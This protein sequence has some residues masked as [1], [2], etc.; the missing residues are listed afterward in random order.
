M[1]DYLSGGISFSGIGNGTDFQSMIEQLKKIEEIPKK[2]LESSHAGWTKKYKAFEGLIDTVK[3]AEKTLSKFNSISSILK[4]TASLSNSSVASVVASADVPD[5][6]YSIDVKQ[7]A[8]NS[9]LSNNTVFDSKTKNINPGSAT[10][11][12][13][14]EYKGQKYEVEVPPNADLEYLTTL[15][16]KDSSNPGVKASLVKTGDGYMFSLEGNETGA[17]ATLNI[18]SATT[19]PSFSPA[20]AT[21]GPLANGPDTIINTTGTVQQ[22]SVNYN[23]KDITFDIPPGSTA[24]D[25]EQAINS[26]SETTGFKASFVKDGTDVSLQL[27]GSVSGEVVT[28]TNS[29]TDLGAF[30]SSGE[31]GWNK[32]DAQDA[33]FSVNDWD[34]EFTSSSN[35][36]TEVIEGLEINLTDTGKTQ[37]TVNTSTK[38]SKEEIEKAV[39]SINSVLGKIQE[40]TSV[41]T[42]KT[43]EEEEL[44][45][46]LPSYLAS[47]VDVNAGPFAGSSGLQMFSSRFKSILSS[48]GVGF[49]PPQTAGGPGDIFSSLASIGI[50]IDAEE[51]SETFGKLKI[52]DRETIGANSPFTT[53]DEALEKDPQSVADILAGSSGVSDSVAFSYET[54]LPGTTK[55]GTYDVQY[56]VNPDGTMGDVFIGGVKAT[57]ADSAKN[58]YTVSSGPA[59]GL[60]ITIKDMTPGKSVESTVRVQQGKIGELQE[61]LKAETQLDPLKEN[62][63]P[64]IIMQDSYKEV[65]RNIETKLERET[66]RITRWE[67]MMRL[68]FSRLDGVLAKYDQMMGANAASLGQLG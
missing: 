52:L 44:S 65:M 17:E 15:I 67:R 19:L 45:N 34:Q 37:I 9:V 57:L 62:T 54:H 58:I 41:S 6:T 5:G 20:A 47:P 56:T 29:P 13:A 38:E 53:L 21:S 61:S 23:G 64:L 12:F 59:T 32:R 11:V 49:S 33:I 50:V 2:R 51:G 63:G 39:E 24:K 28:V 66:E 42:D 35:K 14:Y 55:P 22:F 68:R 27:E 48:N 16:N 25:L 46:Q 43:E 7:L 36:L 1:A 40:L 4:K 3:E 10:A 31:A 60:S 8:T 18:S 26:N 30:T